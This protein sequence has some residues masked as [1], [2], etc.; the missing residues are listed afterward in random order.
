MQGILAVIIIILVIT[1]IFLLTKT[2]NEKTGPVNVVSTEDIKK[3]ESGKK[4]LAIMDET[5]FKAEDI[6]IRNSKYHQN[7]RKEKTFKNKIIKKYKDTIESFK[8]Y[9][10]KRK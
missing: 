3:A 2:K 9:Q 4:N 6:S 8:E 10:K 5:E 1:E 7:D